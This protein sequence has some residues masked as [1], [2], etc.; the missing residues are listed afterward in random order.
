LVNKFKN[1]L[2]LFLSLPFNF[3]INPFHPENTCWRNEPFRIDLDEFF[4]KLQ[5]ILDEQQMERG[6]IKR[7]KIFKFTVIN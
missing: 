3:P 1:Q 7:S 4:S 2:N 5:N 6:G